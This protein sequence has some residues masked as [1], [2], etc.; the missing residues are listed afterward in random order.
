MANFNAAFN[1]QGAFAIWR[2]IA[3]NNVAQVK[4]FCEFGITFPV[5]ADSMLINFIRASDKVRKHRCCAVSNH[6]N[7]FFSKALRQL[8]GGQP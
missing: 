7:A 2:W 1:L 8:A 5:Y 3:F 4:D 6:R